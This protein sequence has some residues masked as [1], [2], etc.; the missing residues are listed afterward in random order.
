MKKSVSLED[1]REAFLRCNRNNFSYQGQ[2]VLFNYLEELERECATELELD[3]I[4]LCC[5]FVEDTLSN[6]LYDYGLES[7]EELRDKTTVLIVTE[8]ADDTTII[9]EVF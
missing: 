2:E 1:F 4:A 8:D 7:L 6:V 9:Y 3:V 5:A